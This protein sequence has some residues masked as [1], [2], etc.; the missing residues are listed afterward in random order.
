MNSRAM[1]RTLGPAIACLATFAF[2]GQAWT[3]D[4]TVDWHTIDGGGGTSTGGVYTVT[5]TIGQP[6]ASVTP[7]SGGPYC[8][9]GGF[10]VICAVQTPGAPVL[11]IVPAGAGQAK[12]SWEPDSPG[13]VLQE[14]LSLSPTNWT[15]SPSGRTNPAVVPSAMPTK[16]YRLNRP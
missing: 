7:M 4:Y 9:T 10:W 6:D 13:W 11:T 1:K 16:F 5:G 14:T 3:Q 8:L 15:D 2:C 12:I